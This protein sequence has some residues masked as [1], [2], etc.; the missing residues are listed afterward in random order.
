[1][2]CDVFI[3]IR[4]SFSPS[5]PTVSFRFSIIF[6]VNLSNQYGT[7]YSDG[8]SDDGYEL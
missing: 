5:V 7:V 2:P 3:V 1:M 6:A 4:L 8:D